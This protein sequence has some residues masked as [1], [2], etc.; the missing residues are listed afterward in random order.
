MKRKLLSL[1]LVGIILPACV[2]KAYNKPILITLVVNG[3]KDIQSV[4]VRGD[5][6]TLSWDKDFP[7]K[8]LVKDS[9][10]QCLVQTR[11]GGL[12]GEIKFTVNGQWEFEDQPNRIIKLAPGTDTTYYNAVF[13]KR[14]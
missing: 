13:N 12:E 5:G 6:N 9:L 4:G 10:Y 8:E 14:E 2:Q 3:Q 7:M 1:I 11:T